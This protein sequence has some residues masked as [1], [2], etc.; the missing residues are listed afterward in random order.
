MR[1]WPCCWGEQ[2]CSQGCRACRHS[3]CW[4]LYTDGEA[5]RREVAQNE[6]KDRAKRF[7]D[8]TERARGVLAQEQQ[9]RQQKQAAE[10]AAAAKK[11]EEA[12]VAAAAEAAAKARADTLAS[13]QAEAGAADQVC[14]Q[15]ERVLWLTSTPSCTNVTRRMLCYWCQPHDPCH[16]VCP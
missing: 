8:A 1:P 16:V 3:V 7:A 6:C 14:R 2:R 13:Q 10:A 12:A 4:T 11:A 5:L 9:Q 15:F